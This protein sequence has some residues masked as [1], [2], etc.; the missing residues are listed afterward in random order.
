VENVTYHDISLHH[1]YYSIITPH[2][3]MYKY[4]INDKQ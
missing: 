4:V 1:G 2:N 3:Y